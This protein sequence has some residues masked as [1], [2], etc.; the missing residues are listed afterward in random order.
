MYIV[1]CLYENEK[2]YKTAESSVDMNN[3]KLLLLLE[4]GCPTYQDPPL[5]KQEQDKQSDP[6]RPIL[7][8]LFFC[9]LCIFLHL[10]MKTRPCTVHF[11]IEYN[12]NYFTIY[13]H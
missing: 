5:G 13:T 8:L 4:I 11:S 7:L 6:K 10:M 12:N 9:F 2:N 3:V 1:Q